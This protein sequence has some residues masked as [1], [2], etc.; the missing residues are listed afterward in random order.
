MFT[1][2]VYSLFVSG[3]DFLDI[4]KKKKNKNIEMISNVRIIL[5]VQEDVH[6][7]LI[8]KFY[9]LSK[10]STFHEFPYYDIFTV[11]PRGLVHYTNG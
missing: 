11:F 10:L 9:S 2:I 6:D 5:Y 3:Q 1:L 4:Q 7:L 8:D